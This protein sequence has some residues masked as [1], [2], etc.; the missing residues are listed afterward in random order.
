MLSNQEIIKKFETF[1][2]RFT[3]GWKREEWVKS[4]RESYSAVE[5]FS[6]DGGNGQWESLDYQRRESDGKPLFQINKLARVINVISGFQIQNRGDVRY[7]PRDIEV[8][9]GGQLSEKSKLSDLVNDGLEFIKHKSRA[10]L[11]NSHANY[12]ALICGIGAVDNTITYEEGEDGIGEPSVQRIAP[13]LLMWDVASRKKNMIDANAVASATIHDKDTLLADI[14]SERKKKDKLESLPAGNDDIFLSSHST[15]DDNLA[16]AYNFQWREKESYLQVQNSA[17]QD[18]IKMQ[19]LMQDGSVAAAKE[20]DIDL[21]KDEIF[22]I[23]LDEEGAFNKAFE[24]VG[25][26]FEVIKQKKY[27]YYRASIVGDMVISASENYSQKGFSLKFI[28]G[29]WS[30]TRQYW[31]GLLSLAIDPQRLFNKGMS[32]IAE[33]LYISPHGGIVIEADAV[34]GVGNLEA[35]KATWA[36]QREVTIIADGAIAGQKFMMKPQAQ[37]S[38]AAMQVLD[39]AD[40]AILECV[41]LNMEFMGVADGGAQQ[42]AMLQEQR[43]KQGMASFANEVD[44]FG[45]FVQEQSKCFVD[46]LRV[47]CQNSGGLIIR[48]ISGDKAQ[49]YVKLLDDQIATEYDIIVKEVPKSSSERQRETDILIQIAGMLTQAGRDGGA[50]LPLIIENQDINSDKL[51]EVLA[52]TQPPPPQQPD[53]VNQALLQAQTAALMAEAKY[54]ESQAKGNDMDLLEKFKT[55]REQDSSEMDMKLE[56]MKADIQKTISETMVNYSKLGQQVPVH[57]PQPYYGE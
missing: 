24:S 15:Q 13:H 37:L 8:G 36:K 41:G 30:E 10:D 1:K 27:V 22:P 23:S 9:E 2:S 33:T 25:L 47:L 52:A 7:I 21:T 12:D 50:I 35:F 31:Y 49:Q 29:K 43:V 17:L 55:M 20:R 39:I 54:K 28:T 4:M 48:N 11:E 34:G 14:N 40:R 38:P 44:S 42:A 5:G 26:P 51:E 45:F 56:K 46:M 57:Q 3:E 16:V 18:P 53:P 32:D 6:Y 19:L